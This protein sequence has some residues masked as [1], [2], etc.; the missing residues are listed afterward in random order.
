MSKKLFNFLLGIVAVI[1]IAMWGV[2]LSSQSLPAH[3]QA[4]T[5][6]QAKA[7]AGIRQVDQFYILNKK[8]TTYTII[9]PN[10]DHQQMLFA[11]D[12]K[13]KQTKSVKANGMVTEQNALAITKHDLPK[14]KV[15]E[16]RLGVDNDQFVWEVSFT[17]EKG[18]L[19]Y[20]YLKATSGEWY[21]TINN[22]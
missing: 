3:A 16:A 22:L 1:M 9:G 19:G 21:E 20:H 6:A 8:E 4:E 5:F 14:V 12:P 15:G 17:D 11:Y 13:T 10:K 18:Q 2:Y 7:K